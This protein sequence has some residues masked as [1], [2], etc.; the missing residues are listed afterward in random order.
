[1]LGDDAMTAAGAMGYSTESAAVNE[2]W[3]DIYRTNLP[4]SYGEGGVGILGAGGVSYATYFDGDPAWVY[5][6][7]WVPENHWNNYLARNP[8]FSSW[9][10]TNMW[11]ERV[12]ASQ[13]GINGFTLT[14]SNNAAAQGGYLGNYILG[15]QLLFDADDVAAIMDAA[16]AGN[17]GIATDPTYSG[18]TYYLTHALRGL[19]EP[20]PDYYTGLPTSQVYFNPAT[21][22]R[23]ALI[24]NPAATNQAVNLYNQG[25]MV[26][27]YTVPANMLS[28]VTPGYTNRPVLNIQS[29]AVVNWP[30]I[31][32]NVYEP[33]SSPGSSVWTDASALMNGDGTTGSLFVLGATATGDSYR[34]LQITPPL[35][36]DNSVISNGGFELGVTTNAADW[37]VGVS[38]FPIRTP[39]AAHSGSFSMDLAVTNAASTPNTSSFAQTLTNGSIVAGQTYNF[40]FWAEQISSGV[41]YVQNYRVSWLNGS[42][43]ALSA[44][45]WNGFSGGNGG[46]AQIVAT[47]LTAPA[48]T[49]SAQVEISG[50]TGTVLNGH[51]E[52]LIDDVVL[53]VNTPSQTNVLAAVAQPAVQ[54]DWSSA[55]GKNYDVNWTGNLAAN[56]WSNLVS[57]VPGNGDTNA[58]CDAIS[59]NQSRF[60]RVTELP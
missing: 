15:Y 43:A 8:T 52:V 58:V 42:G 47:N 27:T 54:L 29:G 59:T 48:S 17:V 44:V 5:A 25:G 50:T 22:I 26:A 10:L 1:M 11:N 12:I 55:T 46:W 33:Q 14:D 30:T 16:Y 4:A 51:G 31:N 3:Q 23:T 40:L 36:S 13:Y 35:S 34:V 21:G 24:Y 56:S 41:S 9:Q 39:T 38:Q 18:V 57:S 20:D 37:S 32:G 28:V 7:Q 6:I 2:Y 49:V 19:G 53:A 60:Y 45:G